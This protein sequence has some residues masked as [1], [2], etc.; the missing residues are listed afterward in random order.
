MLVEKCGTKYGPGQFARAKYV[1][2]QISRARHKQVGVYSTM[3]RG[4]VR[5]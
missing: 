3:R 1:Q 4:I 2:R 5:I